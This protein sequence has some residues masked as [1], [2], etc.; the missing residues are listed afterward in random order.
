MFSRHIH[1]F[2]CSWI[3]DIVSLGYFCFFSQQS[4]VERRLWDEPFVI[5]YVDT[6]VLILRTVYHGKPSLSKVPITVILWRKV[7]W[8]HLKGV[9]TVAH[10]DLVIPN[11][12]WSSNEFRIILTVKPCL[13]DFVSCYGQCCR[14]DF[15]L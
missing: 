3:K 5:K 12:K 14:I 6:I 15:E 4:T 1:S 11:P 10:Y 9:K 2:S 8:I 7:R 13:H